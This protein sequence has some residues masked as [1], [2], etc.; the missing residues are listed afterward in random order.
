VTY[1][2]RTARVTAQPPPFLY[3]DNW[4]HGTAQH[5]TSPKSWFLVVWVPQAVQMSNYFITG[6]G[7]PA[8]FTCLF[9]FLKNYLQLITQQVVVASRHYTTVNIT[10]MSNEW[11]YLCYRQ[12]HSCSFPATMAQR[13][14]RGIG[15][16][17]LNLSTRWK[18][19]SHF[20]PAEG[21]PITHWLGSCMDP[22]AGLGV[23]KESIFPW[24]DSTLNHPACGLVTTLNELNEH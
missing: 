5:S 16:L 6:T 18:F 23:L 3:A 15:P 7:L 22:R 17:V 9:L 21:I 19:A 20:T 8:S 11:M 10:A 12:R 1:W 2:H 24:R 13:R 4:Q 14:R